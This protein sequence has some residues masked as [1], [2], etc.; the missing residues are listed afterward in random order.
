VNKINNLKSPKIS[1]AIPVYNEEETILGLLESIYSQSYKPDEIIISDGGS[2]DKTI[3]LIEEFKSKNKNISI[4]IV[5][6]KNYCRGSGRNTAIENCKN[7]FIALID[8][9]HYASKDWLKNFVDKLI[10]DVNI[11]IIYGSVVPNTNGY[12]N[13]ILSSFLL[14]NRKHN[15]KIC[16]SVASILIRKSLFYEIGMFKESL[17]GQYV[18]EDLDFL[19]KIKIHKN[20]KVKHSELS[21]T[22]WTP[23]KNLSE[24]Y[25][26]YLSYSL[27]A[28]K[29]GYFNVWHLK[30]LRNFSILIF[31]IFLTIIYSK[32][33]ILII[34][35]FIIL[36]SIL[37]LNK[38]IWY[39]KSSILIKFKY[40]IGKSFLLLLLDYIA[41]HGLLLYFFKG[42]KINL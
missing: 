34:L 15:G 20:I 30:V 26:K 24:F 31:F 33:I 41:M 37:Y 21:S 18:V 28:V 6:R 7:K 19:K 8:S 10:A 16:Q 42:N 23:A 27:G 40:I 13:K 38:N 17:D 9:G 22:Y 4:K 39:T 3:E 35:F 29:S 2:K 5:G 25:I 32:F 36:R 14:G 1:I 12:F 11:D